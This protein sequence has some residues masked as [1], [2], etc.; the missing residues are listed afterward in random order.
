MADNPFAKYVVPGDNPF[1]KYAEAKPL[2]AEAKPLAA[3]A[4]PLA[5]YEAENPGLADPLLLAAQINTDPEVQR[6]M[7]GSIGKFVRPALEAAG[8]VGG[9]LLGTP[10]GP[11]GVVAGS[12]L[13][14]AGVKN[15]ERQYDEL[16]GNVAPA[17]SFQEALGNTAQDLATGATYEM[18][19]Q[20]LA[21]G[22][23]AG[24]TALAKRYGSTA[25]QTIGAIRDAADN[26]WDRVTAS[27]DT[28]DLSPIRA[29][30]DEIRAKYNYDPASHPKV[31]AVLARIEQ[32]ATSGAN[33]GLAELRTIRRLLQDVEIAPTLRA[34]DPTVPA[35][36]AT[37]PEK[38]MVQSA[39]DAVDDLILSQPG[40]GSGKGAQ[41]WSDAR[42]LESKLFRSRDVRNIVQEAKQSSRATSAEIRNQFRD[43]ANSPQ[44]K[45]YT[46]EERAMIRSIAEGGDVT[47]ALEFI[48]KAAPKS[49][50][51]GRLATLLGLSGAGSFVGGPA[52]AAVGAGLYGAGAA[53]RGVANRLTVNS[54]NELERMIRGQ[55]APRVFQ[56]PAVATRTGVPANVFSNYAGQDANQNAMAPD[57]QR[58]VRVVFPDAQ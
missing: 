48:G 25:P 35:V 23:G 3:E 18:G 15:L 50:G 30:I 12:A 45:S 24:I 32:A 10:A 6:S 26:I 37:L 31:T 17:R 52:G 38:G 11:A 54:A 29:R 13:G 47:A 53:A 58:D 1:A 22:L 19:G 56:M 27:M 9:G 42:A 4:K 55:V 39:K 33:V 46:P 43:I 5:R 2:A 44:I 28:Y 16:A 7:R 40:T 8:A 36:G 34:H 21:G 49:F 57:R 20:A 51:M 14:Y 41:L